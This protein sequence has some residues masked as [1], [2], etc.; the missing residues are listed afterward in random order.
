MN[1]VL[2]RAALAELYG[3]RWQE[4]VQLMPDNQVI[5]VYFRLEK[6][7]AFDASATLVKRWPDANND[8]IQ[9]NKEEVY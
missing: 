2:L 4:Q 7:G 9:N 8:T 6:A 3:K 5:A 1:V